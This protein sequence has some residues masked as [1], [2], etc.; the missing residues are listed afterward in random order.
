MSVRRSGGSHGVGDVIVLI[1]EKDLQ[2][3]ALELG[4]PAVK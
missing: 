1:L 4:G 3:R 2:L